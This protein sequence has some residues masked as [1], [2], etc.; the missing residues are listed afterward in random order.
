MKLYCRFMD[1]VDLQVK[2]DLGAGT[3]S[4]ARTVNLSAAHCAILRIDWLFRQQQEVLR[5]VMS[6]TSGPY[7]A[8]PVKLERLKFLTRWEVVLVPTQLSRSNLVRGSSGPYPAQ[9]VKLERLKF[10]T[11]WE[12]AL[13]PTQLNR[14][15]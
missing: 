6:G 10:L 8:Q 3:R 11:R 12:V 2:F 14:S 13:V 4:A 5:E 9:P 1:E 15:N 7:P